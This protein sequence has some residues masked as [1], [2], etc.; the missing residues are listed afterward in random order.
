MHTAA[1]PGGR[2]SW[3][4]TYIR[5]TYSVWSN[6]CHSGGSGSCVR[7]THLS[8]SCPPTY[9]VISD[10]IGSTFEV[11]DLCIFVSVY[12]TLFNAKLTFMQQNEI[13]FEFYKRSSN[14]REKIIVLRFL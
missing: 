1:S 10:D 13:K 14:L 12:D 6:L 7:P 11:S 4:E 9:C 3:W 8:V 5:W 2:D